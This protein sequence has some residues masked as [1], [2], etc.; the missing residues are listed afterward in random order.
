M[1]RKRVSSE[2]L[3]TLKIAKLGIVGKLKE[4]FKKHEEEEALIIEYTNKATSQDEGETTT[5]DDTHRPASVSLC[6]DERD[7]LFITALERF[8]KDYEED[9]FTKNTLKIEIPPI[10]DSL[11]LTKINNFTSRKDALLLNYNALISSSGNVDVEGKVKVQAENERDVET[12]MDTEEEEMTELA[13][14]K[15]FM[16]KKNIN[17]G[18]GTELECIVTKI[19]ELQTSN[20]IIADDTDALSNFDKEMS[21]LTTV[22]KDPSKCVNDPAIMESSKTVMRNLTLRAETSSILTHSYLTSC[23]DL[24]KKL[25]KIKDKIILEE[26][27]AAAANINANAA[28][29]NHPVAVTFRPEDWAKEEE[30]L[31]RKIQELYTEIENT[32]KI[33]EGLFL[34]GWQDYSLYHNDLWKE[35]TELVTARDSYFKTARLSLLIS[36]CIKEDDE[37]RNEW[38]KSGQEKINSVMSHNKLIL[39]KGKVLKS[40]T[41]VLETTSWNLISAQ[42]KQK[43][44]QQSIS[45]SSSSSN[46]TMTKSTTTAMMSTNQ[47]KEVVYRNV[48]N[49]AFQRLMKMNSLMSKYTFPIKKANI[50]EQRVNAELRTRLKRDDELTKKMKRKAEKKTMKTKSKT[51]SRKKKDTSMDSP[52]PPPPPPLPPPVIRKDDIATKTRPPSDAAHQSTLNL[53]KFVSQLEAPLTS[54]TT[55]IAPAKS[56]TFNL[57]KIFKNRQEEAEKKMR[58]VINATK[59]GVKDAWVL[60]D[61]PVT[62]EGENGIFNIVDFNSSSMK[63]ALWNEWEP[64]EDEIKKV[65]VLV[66]D[67]LHDDEKWRRENI[68][69]LESC[70]KMFGF[71]QNLHQHVDSWKNLKTAYERFIFEDKGTNNKDSHSHPLVAWVSS[72]FHRFPFP[73][74]VAKYTNLYDAKQLQTT[75]N[76]IH[77][78]YSALFHIAIYIISLPGRSC[79]SSS[80]SVAVTADLLQLSLI[81][82]PCSSELYLLGIPNAF[83]NFIKIE[84]LSPPSPP[85][86]CLLIAERNKIKLLSDADTW[87]GIANTLFHFRKSEN[88]EV[89]L[90]PEINHH[91]ASLW[92]KRL[93]LAIPVGPDQRVAMT[94]LEPLQRA[95]WVRN[96]KTV[97]LFTKQGTLLRQPHEVS[98]PLTSSCSLSSYD[99]EIDW[100]ETST[101]LLHPNRKKEKLKII[102]E[103]YYVA[104]TER[105]YNLDQKLVRVIPY[106]DTFEK[107]IKAT[108]TTLFQEKEKQ[109]SFQFQDSHTEPHLYTRNFFQGDLLWHAKTGTIDRLN[110]LPKTDSKL[111][112]SLNMLHTTDS[113]ENVI[114]AKY[115][116]SYFYDVCEISR[117]TRIFPE[118]RFFSGVSSVHYISTMLRIFAPF[119]RT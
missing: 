19:F 34:I 61:E 20:Q 95:I 93:A 101:A 50:K 111:Y 119:L 105:G 72:Y 39:D 68:E 4:F 5:D 112:K 28:G 53:Q 1:N 116:L 16:K 31:Q 89:R 87:E 2:S 80:S 26:T 29:S 37:K 91:P 59:K 97:P 113:V 35:E 69:E 13:L 12:E 32:R 60:A 62:W 21:S 14:L 24:L 67:D 45:S 10:P 25:Q 108:T 46:T 75:F 76:S 43:Q 58:E 8:L 30:L 40:I 42:Q 27:T 66:H 103:F 64:T 74:T 65:N 117:L 22:I 109:R 107:D 92:V 83:P 49:S 9:L 78:I 90:L 6:K 115:M 52:P 44:Q 94:T 86:P 70:K 106:I 48:I 73:N 63:P 7:R 3:S 56:A 36:K 84:S 81:T 54:L 118:V 100:Y 110:P 104:E 51:N 77:S 11:A 23:E 41:S 88:Y 18:I 15:S 102:D 99:N 17:T 85:F 33:C 96:M 55:A 57:D 71:M 82:S 47:D 79:S 38:F 98:D 114:S